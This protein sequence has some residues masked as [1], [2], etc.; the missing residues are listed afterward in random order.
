[1]VVRAALLAPNGMVPAVA[2]L[3][4]GMKYTGDYRMQEEL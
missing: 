4:Q 3:Q 2:R 1:V